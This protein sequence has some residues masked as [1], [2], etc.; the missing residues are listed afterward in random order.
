MNNKSVG[1][2]F[3][4]KRG[5]RRLTILVVAGSIL[6]LAV[7][8]ALV[9]LED[10][11]V[12]FYSP[13]DVKQKSISAGTRM[14]LGG[15]VE[16]GS[17]IRKTDAETEFVVTD[18]QETMV[19]HYR[20]VLPDLFR[21]G[22]GVIAEGVLDDNHIL[23]AETVLARHDENYMPPEVAEALKDKGYWQETP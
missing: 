11:V 15:L 3:L 23:R 17:I 2:T 16:D 8:L 21:E 6:S 9:A 14:R 20:G 7:G 22:Q 18:L 12:Y 4:T 10:S 13:A 5:W 19:V 1:H